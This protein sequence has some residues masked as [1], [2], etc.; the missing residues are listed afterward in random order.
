MAKSKEDLRKLQAELLQAKS[1][2][3]TKAGKD[4]KSAGALI[5][6]QKSLKKVG[7]ALAEFGDYTLKEASF[8]AHSTTK[9]RKARQLATDQLTSAGCRR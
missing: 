5:A 7:D 2:V 1:A 4:A 3:K 9:E 8:G 6:I